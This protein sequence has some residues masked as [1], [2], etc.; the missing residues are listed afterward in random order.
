MRINR[1]KIKSAKTLKSTL[2]RLKKQ[3]KRVAFTNGCF[4][5]LHSGHVD[6][7]QKAKKMAD[8][9]VVALNSDTSVK[10]IKGNRRPIN[11]LKNRL[12]IIAGL[13]SV[14]FVTYFSQNTP[15][16]IIKF[17]RPDILIKGGDWSKHKVIGADIVES[18]GGRT[19]TVD[20]IKG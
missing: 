1:E 17:L 13:E 10:R 6:Y 19:R 18:Y 5:I 20:Y 3:G 14:D 11:S 7:L 8:V 2:L 4:D 15:L 12:K 9:L 16:E